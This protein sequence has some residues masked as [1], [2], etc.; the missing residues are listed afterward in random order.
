MLVLFGTSFYI[1]FLWQRAM[2][3]S[4]KENINLVVE[5]NNFLEKTLINIAKPSEKYYQQAM[6][7]I[8]PP[9]KR[10][11]ETLNLTESIS[12]EAN[13][14]SLPAFFASY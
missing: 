7:E 11:N 10:W 8:L 1:Y 6:K 12:T 4:Y 5:K 2:F 14:Y 3:V 9:E 13:T